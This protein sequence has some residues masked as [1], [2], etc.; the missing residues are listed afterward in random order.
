MESTKEHVVIVGGGFAGLNLVKRLDHKRFDVTLV[1]SHNYH[2]FPPLFYQVASAELDPASIN[3]PMRREIYRKL[4]RDGSTR[5]VMATVTGID[6]A[7]K[8]VLTDSLTIPYDKLIIAVGTTNNFFNMPRLRDKV[9]TLK[10]TPEALRCRNEVLMRLERASVCSSEAERRRMLSFVVVGGGPTGVE[11]AGALGEMKRYVVEREYPSVHVDEISVTLLEGAPTVLASMNPQSARRATRYLQ[12]LMV[13]VCT[14]ETMT[15]Y[16]GRTVTLRSGRSIPAGVLLWTA[17]VTAVP[18]QFIG[19]DV[20]PG[21]GNRLVVDG[22]NAVKGLTDVWAVGDVCIMPDADPAFPKGHP[23][24]AQVAIQQARLLARNLN[25]HTAR[26]FRYSDRGSMATVGRNR[27][28]V[29]LHS[30]HFGG[31][32]AWF[33][34][35]FIHLVSLLGMRNKLTVLINWMWAYFSYQT[36]LRML[37]IPSRFPRAHNGE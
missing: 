4:G 24:L 36:S 31:F 13:T 9:F 18:L 19:A 16:D 25:R 1:D 11:I 2:S 15:D 22:T 27:A 23:Q 20:T 21:H 33:M 8:R 12:D 32:L 6:V 3:F 26:T 14:G 10:S 28:V 30:C 37:F 5:F 29:D 7:T 17:G 34:W 35:M